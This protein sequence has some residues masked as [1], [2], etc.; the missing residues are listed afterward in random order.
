MWS[1]LLLSYKATG[2]IGWKY[3]LY[4]YELLLISSMVLSWFIPYF[5]TYQTLAVW[6]IYYVLIILMLYYIRP[7]FTFIN[8]QSSTNM[9]VVDTTGVNVSV[10]PSNFPS[11]SR[12]PSCEESVF[13]F[14]VFTKESVNSTNLSKTKYAYIFGSFVCYSLYAFV[15]TLL[16]LSNSDNQLKQLSWYWIVAKVMVAISWMYYFMLAGCIFLYLQI[17][18]DIL[19]HRVQKWIDT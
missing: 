11:L 12:L 5:K 16:E 7:K 14:T 15:Y 17:M 1:L 8:N 10:D 6:T 13:D 2:L 18:C 9:S 19:E 4:V 3:T